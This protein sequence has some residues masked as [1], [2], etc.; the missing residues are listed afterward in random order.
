MKA[1]YALTKAPY[2]MF[3]PNTDEGKAHAEGHRKATLRFRYGRIKHIIQARP[4]RVEFY[5]TYDMQLNE[6]VKSK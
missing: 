3:F 1:M 5:K 6:E 2:V 4:D